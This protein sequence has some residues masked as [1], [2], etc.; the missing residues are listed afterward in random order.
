VV[1]YL[2]QGYNWIVCQQRGADVQNVTGDRNHWYG[3]T[4]A[5]NNRQTGWVSALDARSGE[6]YGRFESAPDC[7]GAHGRAPS[8]NGLW[9]SAPRIGAPMPTP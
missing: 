4:V 1:G 2:H 6:D 8:E 7:N 9:D 5:D 3:W